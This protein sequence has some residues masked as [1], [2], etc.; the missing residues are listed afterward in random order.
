MIVCRI[1]LKDKSSV[2]VKWEG[3][4]NDLCMCLNNTKFFEVVNYST[5]KPE[6]YATDNIWCVRV[7]SQNNKED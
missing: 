4:F 5:N 2:L 6:I 3:T 7:S 1:C